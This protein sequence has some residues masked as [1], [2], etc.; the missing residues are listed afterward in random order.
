MDPRTLAL[1]L[2]RR[3]GGDVTISAGELATAAACGI[4]FNEHD[5]AVSFTALD[6]SGVP[7]PLR[8]LEECNASTA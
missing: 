1:A 8:R 4:D 7:Y 5:G 6:A 2:L 3:L